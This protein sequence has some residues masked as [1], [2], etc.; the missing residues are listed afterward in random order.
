MSIKTA[1]I[2]YGFAAK[3]FH[4][5]F[6]RHLDEFE[7]VAASG[8]SASEAKLHWPAMTSFKD[9]QSMIAEV[10]A[11]LFI[12][13]TPNDTHFELTKAVLARGASVL[14]DKPACT[15]SDEMQ[16]LLDIE[17]SSKGSITVFQNR[18]WD[19]DFLT[20]KQLIKQGRLGDIKRFESH[21]DRARP[22][23][24]QRWREQIGAGAGIWFDLGPHLIDQALQLFGKPEY[25]QADIRTLRDGAEVDDLFSVQLGY[26]DK[27]VTLNSSPFA[28]GRPLRFDVQGSKGRFVKYALDPQEAQLIAGKAFTIP[29]WSADEFANY[30]RLHTESGD[31]R[32]TTELGSYQSLFTQLAKFLKGEGENPVSLASTADQIRIIEAGFESAQQGKRI[33]L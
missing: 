33:T 9:A 19:G 26:Q 14:L 2:G 28:F 32:I 23:P 22:T 13:A 11:D 29:S 10:E 25:V 15:S 31:E 7:L 12:I 4:E 8:S 21:F 18:R 16:A 17:A 6:L 27:Q 20:L 24:K 30:G 5:P 1:I 3:T